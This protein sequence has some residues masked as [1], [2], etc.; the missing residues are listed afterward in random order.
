MGRDA[1]FSE[2]PS[3][4]AVTTGWLTSRLFLD[5]GLPEDTL[6]HVMSLNSN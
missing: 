3:V 4:H 5:L 1:P 2:L 6:N